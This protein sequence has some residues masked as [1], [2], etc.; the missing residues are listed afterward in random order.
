MILLSAVLLAGGTPWKSLAGSTVEFA[1][2][3]TLAVLENVGEV[4][5][6]VVR[7]GDLDFQVTPQRSNRYRTT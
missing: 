6:T 3:A 4:V 1:K 2:P 5:L 7:S